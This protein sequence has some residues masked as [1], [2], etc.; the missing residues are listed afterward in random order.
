MLYSIQDFVQSITSD[1]LQEDISRH[2][3]KVM[4]LKYLIGGRSDTDIRVSD[5]NG[6]FGFSV[7]LEK[8]EEAIRLSE[9]FNNTSL[10]S[11][12][13]TLYVQSSLEGDH[14]IS[15]LLTKKKPE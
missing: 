11:Y 10:E 12:G 14:C 2:F 1:N 5:V 4:A 15:I 13:K 7:L 9:K 8:E 6:K 3:D